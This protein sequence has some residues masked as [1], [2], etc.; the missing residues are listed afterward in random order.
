MYPFLQIN[1]E[2]L[3]RISALE[4]VC[5]KLTEERPPPAPEPAFIE[6]AT[7][8]MTPGSKITMAK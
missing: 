2:L 1:S 8:A 5:T 3:K 7:V 6:P 4:A